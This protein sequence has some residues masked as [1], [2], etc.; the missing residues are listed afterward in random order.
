MS[1]V[2]TIVLFILGILG[3]WAITVDP[4]FKIAK[5]LNGKTIIEAKNELDSW[6][7]KN[8]KQIM[9]K[10]GI[11]LSSKFQNVSSPYDKTFRRM[12]PLMR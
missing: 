7:S 2:T 5:N 6:A 3:T 4:T 9:E 1:T 11:Y 8:E 10:G 12:F